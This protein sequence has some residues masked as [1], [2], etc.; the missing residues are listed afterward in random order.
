MTKKWVKQSTLCYMYSLN[1]YSIN[2]YVRK[3]H[4][5]A[6]HIFLFSNIK[7]NHISTIT[8][9][10]STDHVLCVKKPTKRLN[11]KFKD[12]NTTKMY[13]TITI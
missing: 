3:E 12:K 5:K 1:H 11:N 6:Y 7:T 2:N 9:C 4:K 13:R 8:G 10:I